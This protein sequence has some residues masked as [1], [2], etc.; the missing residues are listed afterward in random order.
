MG[1]SMLLSWFLFLAI[2]LLGLILLIR[3]LARGEG[4]R[5]PSLQQ[6]ALRIL[7]QRYARGE[8]DHDEFEKRRGALASREQPE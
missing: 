2:L 7:E 6:E 5:E 1:G 4:R 8:I 3:A